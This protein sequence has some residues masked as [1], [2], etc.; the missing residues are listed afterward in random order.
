VCFF[1]LCNRHWFNKHERAVMMMMMMMIYWVLT[2]LKR[3]LSQKEGLSEHPKPGVDSN[4]SVWSRLSWPF[5][6]TRR[7]RL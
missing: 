3:D 1:V 6:V 4:V 2:D 7:F 5:Q